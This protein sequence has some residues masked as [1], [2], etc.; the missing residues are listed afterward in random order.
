MTTQEVELCHRTQP[1]NKETGNG[2][3]STRE[4]SRGSAVSEDKHQPACP[5]TNR[6]EREELNSSQTSS[7]LRNEE[8]DEAVAQDQPGDTGVCSRSGQEESENICSDAGESQNKEPSGQSEGCLRTEAERTPEDQSGKHQPTHEESAETKTSP[9]A[10][11][12]LGVATTPVETVRPPFEADQLGLRSGTEQP[13]VRT[14]KALSHIS[15][16]VEEQSEGVRRSAEEQL[17]DT[18]GVCERADEQPDDFS[19]SLGVAEHQVLEVKSS[20]VTCEEQNLDAERSSETDQEEAG[21]IQMS[22]EE[23]FRNSSR[24]A[25]EQLDRVRG[26]QSERSNTSEVSV[27]SSEEPPPKLHTPP[28]PPTETPEETPEKSDERLL[29]EKLRQMVEDSETSAPP[30]PRPKKRLIPSSYDFYVPPSPPMPRS[31]PEEVEAG[32]PVSASRGGSFREELSVEHQKISA[33]V[34]E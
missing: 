28:D 21:D 24:T 18:H 11:E 30:I 1:Q 19:C 14:L 23:Q 33:P 27:R 2:K 8:P 20:S 5:T 31:T 7:A 29:L 13:D 16:A 34:E 9:S 15:S 3:G 4:H 10:E 12:E 22:D 17:N 25:Q 32:L 26:D 6:P